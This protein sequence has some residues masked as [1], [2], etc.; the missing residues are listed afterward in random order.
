MD[1]W[2]EFGV[3]Y[4]DTA[5]YV[6]DAEK[7]QYKTSGTCG[8]YTM[9]ERKTMQFVKKITKEKFPSILDKIEKMWYLS[10]K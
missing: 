8:I 4:V 10:C 2:R 6:Q 1:F 3:M 5:K 7:Q 9:C